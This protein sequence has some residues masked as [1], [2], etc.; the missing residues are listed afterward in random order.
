MKIKERIYNNKFISTII[1]LSIVFVVVFSSTSKAHSGLIT[2]TIIRGLVGDTVSQMGDEMVESIGSLAS[3][4]I[5]NA[6]DYLVVSISKE[7][8]PNLDAFYR[9]MSG[10]DLF[11]GHSDESGYKQGLK[12]LNISSVFGFA[13]SIIVLLFSLIQ[14]FWA[15]PGAIKDSPIR[16]LLRFI[17]VLFLIFNSASIMNVFLY[18]GDNIW[19]NYVMTTIT[20]AGEQSPKG[21][22]FSVLG[23]DESAKDSHGKPSIIAFGEPLLETSVF[24][25]MLPLY[26]LVP[27]FNLIIIWHLLKGFLRLYIEIIE[28]YLVVVLLYFFF[29]AAA[30]TLV[31]KQSSNVFKAFMRMLASQMLILFMNAVFMAIFIDVLVKG[32][33]T[34]SIPNFIFA[35]AFLRITQRVDSYM[36]MLGLNVAQTG[37][38]TLDTLGGVARGMV[39][40]L[41]TANKARVGATNV[42]AS[43]MLSN[44]NFTGAA[45]LKA[46][47]GLG[48]A[49][50]YLAKGGAVPAGLDMNVQ[51]GQQAH[52][53]AQTAASV[54]RDAVAN[55]SNSTVTNRISGI[56][57]ASKLNGMNHIFDQNG[58]R[59]MATSVNT[60]NLRNGRLE[61]TAK[62]IDDKG[63]IIE[64]APEFSGTLGPV[65]PGDH[66][67]SIRMDATSKNMFLST[68][69]A[70][71]D[72]PGNKVKGDAAT[73]G[74][75][76][77]MSKSIDQSSSQFKRNMGSMAYTSKNGGS[78]SVYGKATDANGNNQRIG[79]ITKVDGKM[80]LAES[81]SSSSLT[82]N[83]K[84]NF[85]RAMSNKETMSSIERDNGF[86]PGSLKWD[87]FNEKGMAQGYASVMDGNGKESQK[88][89]TCSDIGARGLSDENATVTSVQNDWGGTSAIATSVSGLEKQ[90]T[91]ASQVYDTPTSSDRMSG[92]L[93]R[94]V[95][96]M[97]APQYQGMNMIDNTQ[98]NDY[99]YSN[100]M[101][102]SQGFAGSNRSSYNIPMQNIPN[103]NDLGGGSI[104]TSGGTSYIPAPAQQTPH[105]NIQQNNQKPNKPNNKS[106]FDKR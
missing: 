67:E 20:D 74:L 8:G 103:N 35:L 28:R 78:F 91:A 95:A 101:P 51:A 76:S 18:V 34:C 98:N 30:A 3:T 60:D 77:G 21:S 43:G 38:L 86:V 102:S 90:T 45:K 66:K 7:F 14:Y 37:G 73:L 70:L 44:G 27:I 106:R 79:T 19:T 100:S 75:V 24:V 23:Y 104:P 83:E 32:G 36:A 26:I 13:L 6:L 50:S 1:A 71:K 80:M 99:S 63:N 48:E 69:N 94:E 10:Q 25:T 81:M 41:R 31:S 52:V 46:T 93:D 65:K 49:A 68:T 88:M 40:G 2:G 55:P 89:V 57:N 72:N 11:K 96:G 85:K 9:V 82:G 58:I 29:G 87:K 47:T 64:S 92:G 33:W 53:T 62:P 5:E 54:I 61:F 84:D 105:I 16:L 4:A 59:A 42:A 39:A 97:N 17:M 15:E 22:D 12:L 56:D